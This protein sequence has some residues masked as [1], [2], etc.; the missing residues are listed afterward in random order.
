[1]APVVRAL[2]AD[3]DFESRVCVTGQHREMLDQMLE[4]FEIRPDHD[5]DVMRPDQRLADVTAAVLQGVS[6]VVELEKPDVVLVQGDTT[7]TT[8]AAL[9]AFYAK[10]PVGHVEAG[11]RTG[12]RYAPWPEEINRRLTSSLATWHFAPTEG[13]R[14]NLLRE[15]VDPASIF[16][17]G[18]TVIDSLLWTRDRVL[19]DART[20]RALERRFQGLDPTR[21]LLLATVHR[22]ESH[23]QGI[24]E[25]NRALTALGLRDDVE[26][27][28]PVHMNPRVS[29]PMEKGLAEHPHVHLTP[30]LDYPTFVYLMD[31]SYMI[32]TDSGG[33]QEEAPAL[34]RPVL[35]LRGV[36]ERPEA[37]EAGAARI[38][39]TDADEIVG[40]ATR[41]LESPTEYRRM[42]EV[43]NPFG[44]GRAA[45]HILDCLIGAKQRD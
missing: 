4:F 19:G 12:D 9:A 30:P 15:N 22:R 40:E 27:L 16:V 45:T 29:G 18:N 8:S 39:G 23:G 41:L 6:H 14:E 35:V 5:L 28:C 38:V 37:V 11:L 1:M 7:T 3:P 20:L 32:L 26:V 34:G 36:T 44:D 2:E 25:V 43:E 10:V 13:A 33:V 42:S 24:D 17:T 21:R 31:R